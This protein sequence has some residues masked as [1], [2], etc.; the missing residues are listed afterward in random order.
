MDSKWMMIV[1]FVCGCAADAGGGT[2]SIG[3]ESSTTESVGTTET[4]STGATMDPIA[5]CGLAAP[6]EGFRWQC[7]AWDPDTCEDVA[8]GDAL[9]CMLAALAA[10][11]EAQLNINFNG[12]KDG[13]DEWLDI[14]SPGGGAP[15][16]LAGHG[17]AVWASVCAATGLDRRGTQ[18]MRY[19]PTDLVQRMV[20]AAGT[21]LGMD[22]E[23]LLEDIGGWV[24]RLETGR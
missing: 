15:A 20:Q 21:V 6:C 10:G 7:S 9:V 3:S 17:D 16:V 23:E 1:A 2:D 24:P 4:G 22:R 13:E 18:I 19:Y 5:A 8:Y 14:A 12:L 11:D